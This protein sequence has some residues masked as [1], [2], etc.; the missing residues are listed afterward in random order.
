MFANNT[1]DSVRL[2]D[3][4]KLLGLIGIA[5]I[6][7][8]EFTVLVEL[9]TL[10]GLRSIV[11]TSICANARPSGPLGIVAAEE[12]NQRRNIIHLTD[13]RGSRCLVNH[14][15]HVLDE[16]RVTLEPLI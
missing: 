12:R 6:A 2:R 13:P 4:E 14:R 11:K 5:S 9:P 10:S 3:T 16:L 7:F 15:L 1:P 8:I